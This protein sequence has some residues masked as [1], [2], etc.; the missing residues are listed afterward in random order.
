MERRRLGSTGV[1]VSELCLGTMTFGRETDEAES[2][3]ILARYL[4]E[5]GT[6][7]DTADVYGAGASEEILGRLLKDRRDEIFLATKFRMSMGRGRGGASRHWIRTAIEDS[8]RRLQTDHV[9]LYQIHCWDE[10]TPIE[11]TCSTLDDLVHEGKVRYLGASNFAGWQLATA[12]G[13][14]A[15]HGWEPF[16]SLQPQ[17]SLVCREQELLPLSLAEGLALLP[18][19]PLGGGLL[20]GKYRKGEAPPDETRATD[21]TPSS[22][23]IRMRLREE[24]G[25]AIAETVAR[26]AE[27]TGHSRAQVALNWVLNRPGVT[28]PILGARTVEQIDD[29]LGAA[30]WE[31]DRDQRGELDE[32][33]ATDPGYPY[34]FIGWINATR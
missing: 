6:F 5:G 28:S 24:R 2:A 32:A 8:L 27:T 22:M 16:V 3:R 12:L 21:D 25:F 30:G 18:W 15:L 31:L 13:R 1:K 26:I 20:T 23:L 10:A 11:E 33:S 19:S 9:D 14:A 34:D 17:Y 29:N 4:D 7:V